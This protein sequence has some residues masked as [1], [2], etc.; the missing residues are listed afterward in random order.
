MSV[1]SCLW[2]PMW[3]A[4]WRRGVNTPALRRHAERFVGAKEAALA[5]QI[6]AKRHG[7]AIDEGWPLRHALTAALDRRD[8]WVG[9]FGSVARLSQDVAV[10]GHW[11]QAPFI[12]LGTHWG[13]GM[14]TLAH[15]CAQGLKPRFVYRQEPESVWANS[16]AKAAHRLHLKAIDRFGG[17]IRVGG[18]YAQIMDALAEDATPVILIDAPADGRPTLTGRADTN[19]VR[20]RSGLLDMLCRERI[21]YVFYRC[22]FDP[23]TGQRHLEIGP[24]QQP[25][26]PQSIADQAA[27]HLQRALALDSA[28][29][30][31]WMVADALLEKASV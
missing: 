3:D 9:A 14:P 15:L 18:A 27:R 16:A 22:G 19:H 31:L 11:P 21:Q 24:A 28:Q 8:D 1:W 5:H 7:F 26:S 29:W 20:I 4:V 25:Q 23:E 10:S 6:I 12:A 2:L 30:R 13:A 17:S